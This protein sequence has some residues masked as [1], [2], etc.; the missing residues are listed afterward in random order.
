[1][2]TPRVIGRSANRRPVNN[3]RK[4]RGSNAAKKSA[5]KPQVR[6]ENVT[7]VI[8]QDC[9]FGDGSK[10]VST[11]ERWRESIIQSALG[12]FLYQCFLRLINIF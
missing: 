7:V 8:V 4:R 1:M 10:K 11:F 9:T 5:Q 3:T 12:N 2:K 6:I